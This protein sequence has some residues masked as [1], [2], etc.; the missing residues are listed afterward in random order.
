MPA[1]PPMPTARE[2]APWVAAVER[3]WDDPAFEAAHR[4]RARAEAA[5]WDDA[6]VAEKFRDYF[7][8]ILRA[9]VP[10]PTP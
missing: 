7:E 2:A 4:A 3:L 9:G 8:G 5:R 1:V 10:G 6:A